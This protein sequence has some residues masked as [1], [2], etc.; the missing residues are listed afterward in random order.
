MD[1]QFTEQQEILKNVMRRLERIDAGV[2]AHESDH[3]PLST[4]VYAAQVV[5]KHEKSRPGA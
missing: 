1:L 3:G 2:T 5:H 4:V